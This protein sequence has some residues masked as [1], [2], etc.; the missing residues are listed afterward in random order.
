M[1][2]II[3]KQVN[4]K[5]LTPK[6][7]SSE[8]FFIKS[9]LNYIGGKY[10]ILNQIHKLF[11]DKINNFVDLFAG[12]CNVAI[13]VNAKKIY[14]NDSLIYII[15]MYKEFKKNDSRT[16]IKHIN[17]RITKFSLSLS[18]DKGYRELRNLYNKNKNPLDLFVL[19]A[20][21]F[22]HQIRFN[23]NHEFNNPFGKDRSSFNPK[24]KSNLISFINAIQEKNIEFS[25]LCF[26]DFNI[27][28]LRKNDFVYCD[29]PYLITNGTYND[30]KRGFKGWTEKEEK[31]LL[32]L[33]NKLD[34]KKIKFA[35][36]NVVEHKGK[37]NE[38]LKGWI[39]DNSNYKVHYINSNY[40]NSN[41]Q[42]LKKGKQVTKEVLVTNY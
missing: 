28:K 18:N 37:E 5:T 1:A 35:L 25:N 41:Y 29:P 16:I 39:K 20:Y 6:S 23:N 22:N 36:S 24:M 14:I 26:T 34:K 7:V 15:D 2:K 31:E 27:T 32:Q 19:I 9:P 3:N 4:I 12:G 40:N 30:G 13:N 21:S 33:L 17:E 11:P 8:F 42:T 10:K 38:L